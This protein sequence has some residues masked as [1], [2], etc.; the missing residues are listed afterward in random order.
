MSQVFPTPLCSIF[1]NLHTWIPHIKTTEAKCLRALNILKFLFY[2]KYGCSRR[3]LLLLYSTFVRYILN[4]GSPVYGLA[5]PTQLK[6]LDPVQN[7]ALRIA[8]GAFRT[9]PASSLCA[10][11]GVPPLHY[12]RLTL[13]AKFL[14]TIL[15]HPKTSAYFNPSPAIQPLSLIHISEPTRPY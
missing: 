5:S 15:Q 12:R 3:I 11:T 1:H 8:T 2:P 9:S 14:T 10:E 13:T 7:A 6:L 4:Y